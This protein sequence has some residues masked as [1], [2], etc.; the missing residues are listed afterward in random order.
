M[1]DFKKSFSKGPK[2]TFGKPGFR[3]APKRDGFSPTEL[4]DATCAQCQKSCQV[5]FR[6]NG[7]K[8]VLCKDC[9]SSGRPDAPQSRTATRS[10]IDEKP[11][12]DLHAQVALINA[13][14]DT[15]T[16]MVK[17]LAE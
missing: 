5:P 7:K 8:P 1:K 17:G 3:S 13:K 11:S 9:F 15:L 16:R 6:P 14:L 12:G 2:R 4:F 10:Y